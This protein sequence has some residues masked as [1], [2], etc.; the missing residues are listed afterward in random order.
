MAT[1]GENLKRI[2]KSKGLTQAELGELIGQTQACIS[3]WENDERTPRASA[4][5][6]AIARYESDAMLPKYVNLVA[7]SEVLGC[8]I[9]EL[10]GEEP[11]EPKQ[12]E[13]EIVVKIN[14]KEVM[15]W[16]NQ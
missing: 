9:G 6:N 16:A 1:F 15:R 8:S 12:D 3:K 4:S 2:R 7:I 14:G 10:F 11:Q 13:I 5:R